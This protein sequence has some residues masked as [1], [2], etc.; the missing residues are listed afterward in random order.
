MLVDTIHENHNLMDHRWERL[1]SPLETIQRLTFSLPTIKGANLAYSQGE[2][3]PADSS[4]SKHPCAG[5]LQS[6]EII[7]P[8][9]LFKEG[10][11]LLLC[12]S[13]HLTHYQLA[14]N[15]N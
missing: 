2:G 9:H 13:E 3:V 5:N 6:R 15:Y 10:C 8:T 12:S 1:S 14:I 11:F 7:H 4:L